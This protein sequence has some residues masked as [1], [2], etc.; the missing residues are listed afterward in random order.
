MS[1]FVACVAFFAGPITPSGISKMSSVLY[2]C[3]SS[4]DSNST[5]MEIALSKVDGCANCA[6]RFSFQS[7][8]PK[9]DTFCS[10]TRLSRI[11]I[12]MLGKA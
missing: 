12:G 10:M 4:K 11:T 3:D 1:D 6:C 8:F 2:I 7:G 9:P 5:A